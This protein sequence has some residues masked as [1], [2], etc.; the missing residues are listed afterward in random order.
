M[1]MD[2]ESAALE[3]AMEEAQLAGMSTEEA[4]AIRATIEMA[5]LAK[6]DAMARRQTSLDALAKTIG[7]RRTE[8]IEGRS[9]S[10]IEDEWRE[11]EEAYEGID[12]ANRNEEGRYRTLK[13]LIGASVPVRAGGQTRS[14][15]FLNI[16]RP[17]V[18]AASARVS[19][20]LLPTDD[21]S[22]DFK[23][24]P[25]GD[26]LEQALEQMAA[27]DQP[28]MPQQMGQMQQ[29]LM[30]GPGMGQQMPSPQPQAGAGMPQELSGPEG[31]GQPQQPPQPPDPATEA[32]K[33]KKLMEDGRRKKVEAGREQVEDWLIESN[34]HGHMRRAFDDCARI[35]SGVMGGPFPARR[36]R[37]KWVDGRMTVFHEIVPDC[38][39]IDPWNL[40]PDPGCGESI[41][42]GRYIFE[43]DDLTEKTLTDLLRD[44]TYFADQIRMV[45]EEGPRKHTANGVIEVP[46]SS[47]RDN[48]YETWIWYGNIER[49]DFEALGA[50]V[51]DEA[52]IQ[53]PVLAQM[54]ND[55]II[56]IV[57][58]PLDSGEFPYDVMPWSVRK[59]M[60]WGRGVSRQ[61]RTP[62]RM[63]NAGTRNLMDNAGLAAGLILVLRRR[64]LTPSDNNWELHGRKVFF[65]DEAESAAQAAR[66]AVAAIEVPIRVN[67]LLALI[68]FALAM[69]ERVTG[70]PMLLQGQ[71]GEAPD[72]VGGMTMLNNNASGVMR[73]VAR[74][75]DDYIT[76]PTITRYYEWLQQYTDNPEMQ[77]DAVIDARGSTALVERDLQNQWIGQMANFV[78]NPAF[79]IDPAKW[80]EEYSKSVRFDPNR[81][82]YSDAEWEKIQSQPPLEDPRVTAAKLTTQSR[83]VE[84]QIDAGT[85]QAVAQ[86]EGQ[87]RER[88][89]QL[90]AGADLQRQQLADAAAERRAVIEL[91]GEERMSRE[92]IKAR[93][94]EIVTSS[95]DK[96]DLFAA[97]KALKHEFGSGI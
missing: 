16:T 21:R 92:E 55:R 71:M 47:T 48:Q 86:A 1:D 65:A 5:K 50:E 36:R 28:M 38:R 12:E 76:E 4:D 9:S 25:I 32:R 8:A 33:T 15:V 80:F 46:R 57:Q 37:T 75:F 79:K 41:H 10:G 95:R 31:G 42:D 6:Q 53:I 18:D 74:A 77:F 70:M 59:G 91:L 13:P 39:R 58:N 63:I 52:I 69:A 19:D 73:R 81:I 88:I 29:S 7:D 17:F 67:E 3:A 60:P 51:P 89:A 23:P 72:T 54:V 64:G 84:R 22:W 85:R 82:Q 83:Q 26:A 30:M 97:E 90:E 40:F 27:P 68:N 87:V 94:M 45:L 78:L 56:K 49:E 35:G 24:T 43:R 66:D 14:T 96:R 93:L 34:W 20:M 2:V 11:D 44:E 61:S 62:Q